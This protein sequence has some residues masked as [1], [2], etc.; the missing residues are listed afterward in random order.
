MKTQAK[1]RKEWGDS[2]IGRGLRRADE[3]FQLFLIICHAQLVNVDVCGIRHTHREW[4]KRL[5]SFLCS[6]AL[7]SI[8][9][10]PSA[11]NDVQNGCRGSDQRAYRLIQGLRWVALSNDLEQAR[12]SNYNTDWS[13]HWREWWVIRIRESTK[14]KQCSMWVRQKEWERG[15]ESQCMNVCGLKRHLVWTARPGIHWHTCHIPQLCWIIKTFH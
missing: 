11:C 12:S 14:G 7:R 2:K 9:Q 8:C 4:E 1:G 15:R 13:H 10:C 6:P 3:L 5:F